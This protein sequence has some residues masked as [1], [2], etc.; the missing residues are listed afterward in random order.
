MLTKRHILYLNIEIIIFLT[1]SL[2]NLK[3][4]LFY[5]KLFKKKCFHSLTFSLKYYIVPIIKV[6][7]IHKLGH[8]ANGHFLGILEYEKLHYLYTFNIVLSVVH[9]AY[10]ILK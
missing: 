9:V 5:Q 1:T 3:Y 8:V 6:K 7:Y 2:I 10:G 4:I